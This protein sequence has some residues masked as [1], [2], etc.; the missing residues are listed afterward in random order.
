MNKIAYLVACGVVLSL[1]GCGKNK[2]L[3]AAEAFEKEACACKDVACGTA[4]STKFAEATAKD[5]TSVP[6]SG[7]D[8]EAYTAAVAKATECVTKAAMAGIPGMPAGK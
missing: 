2:M 5:A 6:T 7:G 1:V 4:A 3:I 8:A